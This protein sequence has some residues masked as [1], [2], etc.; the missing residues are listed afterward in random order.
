MKIGF[1]GDSITE[2]IGASSVEKNYVSLVKK[3]LNCETVNYGISGT[4]IARQN[5]ISYPHSFDMDFNFRLPFVADDLD[6]LFVFGGTNDYGH[7]DARFGETEE[8][9]V[10]SFCGAVNILIDGLLKKYPKEKIIFI[11]PLQRFDTAPNPT[12]GKCLEDYVKA[13]K[14]IVKNHGVD[15]LDFYNGLFPKPNTNLNS[16]FFAD[17]LHPNDNGYQIIAEKISEY[18]KNKK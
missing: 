17:G 10:S 4:R 8:K 2:G 15:Y 6:Y 11:L 3:I 14:T 16:E 7:G 1:I 12:T 18:I 13:L 5:K 9:D